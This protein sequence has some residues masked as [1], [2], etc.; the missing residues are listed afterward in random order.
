METLRRRLRAGPK[1]N[2]GKVGTQG[3]ADASRWSRDRGLD[4]GAV[5]HIRPL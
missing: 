4:R 5:D 2:R 1:G 3:R